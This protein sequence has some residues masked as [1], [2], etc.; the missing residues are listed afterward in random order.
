MKLRGRLLRDSSTTIKREDL[1]YRQRRALHMD[2]DYHDDE[3]GTGHSHL[4]AEQ[5]GLQRHIKYE[6]THE[7]ISDDG[8]TP[9]SYSNPNIKLEQEYSPKP[10]FELH[11]KRDYWHAALIG[12]HHYHTNSYQVENNRARH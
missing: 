9:R 2:E 8:S 5:Q 3:K 4:E 7:S 12:T 6:K 11:G 10:E 1:I